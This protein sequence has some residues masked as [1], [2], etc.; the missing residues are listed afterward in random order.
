[1]NPCR[2][3]AIGLLLVG[4]AVAQQAAFLNGNLYAAGGQ[5]AQGDAPYWWMNKGSPFKRSYSSDA[6]YQSNTLQGSSNSFSSNPFLNADSHAYAASNQVNSQYLSA[7]S[8]DPAYAAPGYLPPD[9]N[10]R[11]LSCTSGQVCVAKY[12][13]RN[14]LVDSELTDG[15]KSVSLFL[16]EYYDWCINQVYLLY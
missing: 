9:N 6:S 1:M 5:Q 4:L 10:V 13:C 7:A 8:D 2:T 11:T 14:G 3:A 16:S 15:S 12:L